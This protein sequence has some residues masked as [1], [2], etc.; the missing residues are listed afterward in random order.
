M[1]AMYRSIILGVALLATACNKPIDSYSGDSRIYFFERTEGTVVARLTSKSFSFVLM[2]NSVTED[3]IFVKTKIMGL[4]TASDRSFSAV[5]DTGG[6]AAAADYKILP[7]VVKANTIFGSLPVVVYRK[8]ELKT[9]IKVLN[10]KIADGGDFKAGVIDDAKF[11]LNWTDNL[12]KPDNWE[13]TPGLKT[14]F[15]TYSAVKYRFIIDVLGRDQ[16]PIQTGRDLLP[17]QLTHYNMLDLKAILKDALVAYNN[18]HTPAMT[19]EF[20][21]LV[22]FP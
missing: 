6:N 19:D 16:F 22:T 3:T 1:K 17:G 12:I 7:G 14:Y 9:T 4:A 2:D 8:P 18:T 20:G 11:Q 5:A 10:L 15:G 13:T 21:Q